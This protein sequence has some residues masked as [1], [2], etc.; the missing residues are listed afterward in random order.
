MLFSPS[1]SFSSTAASL[2]APFLPLLFCCC[3]F[4]RPSGAILCRTGVDQIS[5]PV[6][7]CG[8]FNP[9]LNTTSPRASVFSCDH[10]GI[11]ESILNMRDGCV[12]DGPNTVCCCSTSDLCNYGFSSA[13]VPVSAASSSPHLPSSEFG[14]P[15][16][17]GGS[18]F[19]RIFLPLPAKSVDGMELC[20]I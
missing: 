7:N 14:A 9:C 11:C 3:L 20:T 10:G 13:S 15:F 16:A 1:A 17:S 6:A 12:K 4:V 19:S 5:G 18:E 8:N 2:L